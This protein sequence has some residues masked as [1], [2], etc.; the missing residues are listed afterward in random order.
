[1]NSER[2]SGLVKRRAIELGFDSVG[3][4]DLRPV[5]HADVLHEW[6]SR[7]M[8]GTMRYMHRQERHRKEPSTILPTASHAIIVS[9]GYCTN[10]VTRP[11]G[12]G[13]VAKY[14]R[15]RDYHVALK[16]PLENLTWYVTSLGG[17]DTIARY[18]VD[19]GPVPERELAQRAG[20]GWIGKN[21]MLLTPGRGSFFFLATVLTSLDLAPDDPFEADRCGSCR[22]CLDACPT[23]A[24][25]RERLLDSRRCI[26]YL[27]IE[28]KGEILPAIRPLLGDWIFGCDVC[29]DVCPWNHKFA[30]ESRDPVL[31]MDPARAFED[32]NTLIQISDAEF[33]SRFGWTPL[34]RPGKRRMQRNAAIA[35]ENSNREATW[36]TSQTQ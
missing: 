11:A 7:G 14:A 26:S 12:S 32:L 10:E 17:A 31:A 34:E 13:R 29:Q 2:R 30:T 24:F 21:T 9:R 36:R 6:L 19:A 27:T 18:Y 8:A 28:H 22:R 23:K 3:I 35:S 15:G 16:R 33:A 20:L 5:P 25:E 4:T 1:M